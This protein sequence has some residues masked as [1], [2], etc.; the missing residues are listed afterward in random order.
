MDENQK[1]PRP[2]GRQPGPGRLD[3]HE[4]TI[5]SML[6]D[7]HRT[8]TTAQIQQHLKEAHGVEVA[9]STLYGF[10]A[11][12]TKKRKKRLERLGVAAAGASPPQE[13]PRAADNTLVTPTISR[14]P[15]IAKAATEGIQVEDLLREA[16]AEAAINWKKKPQK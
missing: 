16:E 9:W 3:A 6:S 13:N 1:K 2:P 7:P 10:I 15:S 11:R 14:R 5:F 12:R 4:A 8:Y